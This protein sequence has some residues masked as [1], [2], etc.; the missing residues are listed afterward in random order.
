MREDEAVVVVED[1]D[2]KR[3]AVA[4]KEVNILLLAVPVPVLRQIIMVARPIPEKCQMHV[5]R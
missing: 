5:L 4:V 2:P 3:E 1:H